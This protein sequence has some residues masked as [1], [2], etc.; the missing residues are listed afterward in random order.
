MASIAAF[1]VVVVFAGFFRAELVSERDYLS[2]DMYRYIWD[3]RVQ[4]AGINPYR[5]LPSAEELKPL[6]DEA[7]Y[8]NINRREYAP[9]IYP[10]A[11]QAIFLLFYTVGD[12]STSAFKTAISIFDLIAIMALALALVYA[13]LDPA[14][15]IFFAWHPLIVWESAH[16]GHIEAAAIAFIALALLGWS[17]E[18]YALSGIALAL[19]TLVKIYPALLLPV[20]AMR[21]VHEPNG[22]QP[23]SANTANNHESGLGSQR[24][25]TARR[26]WRSI[27]ARLSTRF[28]IA[29]VLTI[30]I[31]Y[32]PYST[33]GA[34][35]VGFLPGYLRE[36][37]FVES[38]SRYFP[39]GVA[40]LLLPIPTAVYAAAAGAAIIWLALRVLLRDKRNATDAAWGASSLVGLFLI[41]STPRF[42]WYIAWIVP[43]LCFAPRLSWLY[44]SGASVLLYLLW[45]VSDYPSIPLW[46]GAAMYVPTLALIGLERL[47]ESRT[48]S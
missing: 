23:I 30:L 12:S 48:S 16:S 5:Y 43:F 47:R 2:N 45:L 15:V 3:G 10:P 32:L 41:L 9:T 27:R 28:L 36:E 42:S 24:V 37:G 26:L 19:A 22:V 14:R 31:S 29:F 34:R 40:R 44:L 18:K 39:L 46:L 38:G 35:V 25:E 13:G 1:A 7:I 8:P 17:R 33:A 20:F 11:A 6:R 4:A 21:R